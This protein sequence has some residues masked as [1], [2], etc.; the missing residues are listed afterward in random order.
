MH[1]APV[2][3]LSDAEFEAAV[4]RRSHDVPIVV[5]FWAPW[6]GPCRQ[7]GPILERLAAE[8]AGE[9][10]LVKVNIDNNPRVATEYRVESIP[11]VKGFRDGRI[12]AEFLGA[13]PEAQV[14]SFLTRVVPSEADQLA[15]QGAEM[16]E[17]GYLATA[18][19]RY[20]DALAKS[21]NHVRASIG[22]ARVL[23]ARDQLDEARLLLD[24]FPS[25]PE[26]QRLRAQISLAQF[27]DAADLGALEQ[28]VAANPKDAAAHYEIGRVLAARES[29][30]Q[31]LDHLLTSVRLDRSIDDDGARKAML[32]IFSLLGDNDPHTAQYRRLLQ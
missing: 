25:D 14:R 21:P 32:D 17:S 16:E 12:V 29:Y 1:G 10:E 3:D 6:C 9:W 5:D 13:V 24:R 22:L 31:A 26:G 28:R 18:E 2:R 11:A 27:G 30:E 8:A 19:D 7:I 4:I 15:R 23:V 20:R